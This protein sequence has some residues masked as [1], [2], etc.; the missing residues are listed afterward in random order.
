MKIAT[1]NLGRLTHCKSQNDVNEIYSIIKNTD[2]DVFV[3]TCITTL[4]YIHL[5][6]I[7]NW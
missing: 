6:I 5:L 4:M 7:Q 3:L 1:W 2:A